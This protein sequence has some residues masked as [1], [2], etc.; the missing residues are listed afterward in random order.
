MRRHRFAAAAV[1]M[2]AVLLF[3]TGIRTV[4][5]APR[6]ESVS[7]SGELRTDTQRAGRPV[8]AG[9]RVSIPDTWYLYA[10]MMR[11]DLLESDDGP[12]PVTISDV[13]WPEPGVRHD[14]HLDDEVRYY[15]GTLEFDVLLNILPE[16]RPGD[17]VLTL[18][19]GY[20][21]CTQD[22]CFMPRR[23]E[24]P[25]RLTVLESDGGEVWTG[26]REAAGVESPETDGTEPFQTRSARM[27]QRLAGAGP[28]MIVLLAFLAGLALS[29]TPCVYPMIP[30]TIAV[31]GASGASTRIGAF[32]RSLVYVLGISLTYA[33][34][35]VM[36]AGSGAA[37][38]VQM[39]HPYVY[40]AL[41]VLFF[42]F[43]LGMLGL[44]EISLPMSRLSRVQARLRGKA[45]LAGILLTGMLSGVVVTSCAAPVVFAALGFIV[46]SGDLFHGFIIFTAIAWGMGVPLL[47]AGTFSGAV[48]NMPKSGGWQQV[49]KNLMGLALVGASLYFIHLSALLSPG[50]F[51]LLFAVSLVVV[52]VF[53]GAFDRLYPDAGVWLRLRKASGILLFLGAVSLLLPQFG[54]Q[55]RPAAEQV[56]AIDWHTS[57]EEGFQAAQESGRPVMMYFSTEHCPACRRLERVT[58]P[59]PG[60]VEAAAHFEN[61]KFEAVPLRGEG[62]QQVHEVLSSFG[63]LGFPTIVFA[64]AEGRGDPQL[65]EVGFLNAADLVDL[66]S[67]ARRRL[68]GELSE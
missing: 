16:A 4:S 63:V 53:V 60:V 40:I 6:S 2:S 14:P 11:V 36:A 38:G 15:D 26:G 67:A 37:F 8:K 58:F 54:L 45:G 1:C 44:F 52:S 57:V 66:M 64:R 23:E 9:L 49:V 47:L 32:V 19:V 27:S 65:T 30:V 25:L 22:V 61:I 48:R 56:P 68:E 18:R 62:S 51:S 41:S 55:K 10:H 34:V 42:I 12:R 24:V 50:D 20:Q 5:A 43:A 13:L 7:V 46:A 31:I 59:D 33:L 21:A 3:S 17:H 39:Q 28:G 29:L 35:G